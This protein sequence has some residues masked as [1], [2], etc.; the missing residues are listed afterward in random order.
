MTVT[1]LRVTSPVFSTEISYCSI[2]PLPNFP[3][4]LSVTDTDL[5]TLI[6]GLVVIVTTVGSFAATVVGSSEVSLTLSL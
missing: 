6:D 1:L 3:S 5:R 2:S 4:P